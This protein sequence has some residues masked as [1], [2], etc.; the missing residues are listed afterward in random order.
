M[1]H[2]M[3]LL[4]LAWQ[5]IGYYLLCAYEIMNAFDYCLNLYA[6]LNN[7]ITTLCKFK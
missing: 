3:F 7:A 2:V 4:G 1:T 6:I 5:P